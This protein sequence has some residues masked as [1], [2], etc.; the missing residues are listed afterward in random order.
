MVSFKW[1]VSVDVRT[2][3]AAY[4][5]FGWNAVLRLAGIVCRGLEPHS[6]VWIVATIHI[7]RTLRHDMRWDAESSDGEVGRYGKNDVD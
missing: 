2:A 5:Q 1:S 3:K 7:Q 4:Q 6:L